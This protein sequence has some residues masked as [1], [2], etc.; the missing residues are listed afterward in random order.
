M[1]APIL[2]R[3]QSS[4]RTWVGQ[5]TRHLALDLVSLYT[6]QGPDLVGG[7]ERVAVV[8]AALPALVPDVTVDALLMQADDVLRAHWAMLDGLDQVVR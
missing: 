3:A 2:C 5:D 7:G 8:R 4:A 1:T 6:I